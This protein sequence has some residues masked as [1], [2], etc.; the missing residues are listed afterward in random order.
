ML[1]YGWWETHAHH[2]SSRKDAVDLSF[3]KQR[4]TPVHSLTKS[5]LSRL[6]AIAFALVAITALSLSIAS[7]ASAAPPRD[8]AERVLLAEAAMTFIP[9]DATPGELTTLGQAHG[10]CGTSA[11]YMDVP[12]KGK[13]VVTWSLHSTKGPM[14]HRNLTINHGPAKPGQIIDKG[15]FA[16]LDYSKSRTWTGLKGNFGASL[17]GTVT[18]AGGKC[19]LTST[20]TTTIKM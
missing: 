7:P 13:A 19:V 15:V 16:R 2:R 5:T 10:N 20:Y 11:I 3:T 12:S 1:R 6:L 9:N 8:Q 18:V 17:H 14:I 4:G